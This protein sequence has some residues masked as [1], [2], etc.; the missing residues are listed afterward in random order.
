MDNN[1]FGD[2]RNH[3]IGEELRRF[4]ELPLELREN[5]LRELGLARHPAEQPVFADDANLAADADQAA[6]ESEPKSEV[7]ALY[8][9]GNLTYVSV[10]TTTDLVKSIAE[11]APGRGKRLLNGLIG[12]KVVVGIA[13]ISYVCLLTRLSNEVGS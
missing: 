4:N 3:A 5:L 9:V 10:K 11:I 6:I 13:D 12:R 1:H 8:Y 2:A 7:T